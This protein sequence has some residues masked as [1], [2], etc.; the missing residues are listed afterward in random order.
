MDS[1]VVITRSLKGETTDSTS[2]WNLVKHILQLVHS[3]WDVRLCHV[4]RQAN[5]CTDILANIGSEHEPKL[6]I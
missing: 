2:G 3:D 1:D 5:R 4:Y 6:V